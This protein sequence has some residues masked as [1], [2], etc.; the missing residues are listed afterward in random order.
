MAAQVSKYQTV[1]PYYHCLR[2]RGGQ[3]WYHV[4]EIPQDASFG[5]HLSEAFQSRFK[6]WSF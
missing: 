4:R 2:G 6:R 3:V 1:V 5:F